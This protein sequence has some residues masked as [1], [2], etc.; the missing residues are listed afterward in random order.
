MKRIWCE[1]DIG[2]ENLIFESAEAAR[3]WLHCNVY[4][5]EM[6]DEARQPVEA[7]VEELF[8][9]SYLDLFDVRVIS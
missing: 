6:A 1:W 8:D 3:R 4:M 2:E 7:Y 9:Q 5:Q